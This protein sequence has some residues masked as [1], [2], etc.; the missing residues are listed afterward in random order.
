MRLYFF[1][2]AWCAFNR[3]R[4]EVHL[5]SRLERHQSPNR[6]GSRDRG[7]Q[8]DYTILIPY[9]A[10]LEIGQLQEATITIPQ[11]VLQVVRIG[12]ERRAGHSGNPGIHV[13]ILSIG[14]RKK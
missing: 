5:A 11:Q 1:G 10:S 13:G 3:T 14:S 12:H 8:A 4:L 6:E 7:D 9:P 2:F